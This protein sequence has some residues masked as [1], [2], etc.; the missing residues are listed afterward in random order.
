MQ[1]A[2]ATLVTLRA[3]SVS[4]SLANQNKHM[5]AA[6]LKHFYTDLHLSLTTCVSHRISHIIYAS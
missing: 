6:F 1:C 5:T 3:T 4:E 2:Y